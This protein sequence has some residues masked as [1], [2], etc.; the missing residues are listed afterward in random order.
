[1][2]QY[3]RASFCRT[4]VLKPQVYRSQGSDLNSL[5]M[6]NHVCKLIWLHDLITEFFQLFFCLLY[7]KHSVVDVQICVMLCCDS[8]P[9]SED[10]SWRLFNGPKPVRFDT[11]WSNFRMSNSIKKFDKPNLCCQDLILI[12]PP[13]TL[14]GDYLYCSCFDHKI[15]RRQCCLSW[16]VSISLALGEGDIHDPLNQIQ[17]IDSFESSYRCYHQLKLLWLGLWR[18]TF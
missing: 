13:D 1:M 17:S 15:E 7:I 2:F 5:S 11:H 8:R 4:S 18:L 14:F 6:D 12:L 16:V 3:F 9:W 10:P